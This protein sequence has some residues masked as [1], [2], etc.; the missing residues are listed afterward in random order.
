MQDAIYE[1]IIEE[2]EKRLRHLMAD[3]DPVTGEG[4]DAFLGEERIRLEISDFPIPVQWVPKE[5]MENKLVKARS[6]VRANAKDIG[7]R[8]RK[9]RR[10][11]HLSPTGENERIFNGNIPLIP[12]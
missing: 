1:S 4:L 3:Y 8:N 2:N 10:P 7:K 6:R 12:L 9:K 5:M 11:F